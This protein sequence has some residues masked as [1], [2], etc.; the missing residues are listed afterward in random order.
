MAQQLALQLG[1]TSLAV[2][3]SRISNA[4]NDTAIQNIALQVFG[5]GAMVGGQLLLL[6][7]SRKHEYEADKMGLMLMAKAGYDPTEA[8][9]FW[10][11]MSARFGSGGGSEFLSTHPSNANR[12][13]ALN[14]AL[15][16]AIE[17]YNKSKA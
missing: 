11:R 7:Y 15:P 1:I 12:I 9:K 10:E 8:P 14:D 5:V 6:S 17:I 2:A 3:T 13:R 16:E 4:E